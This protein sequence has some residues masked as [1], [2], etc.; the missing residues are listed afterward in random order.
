MNRYDLAGELQVSNQLLQREMHERRRAEGALGRFFHMSPD[1]MCITDYQGRIHRMN[2]VLPNLLGYKEKEFLEISLSNHI[3]PD[4]LEES[5]EVM[6]RA[7]SGETIRNFENRYLAKDGTVRWLSWTSVPAV[8]LGL[9]YSVGREITQQKSE[10]ELAAQLA[11]IVE[12]SDD[13]I[14]GS[15][16]EGIITSWNHSAK[17]IYGYSASE[18]LGRHITMLVPPEFCDEMKIILARIKAGE[19]LISYDTERIRKDGRRIFVAVT[20]SPIRDA[21]GRWIGYSTIARDITE[22]RRMANELSRLDRLN[23]AGKMAA[24][25][26]HEIRN[27]M[28]TVRGYLQWLQR[29]DGFEAFREQFDLMI[30]ELDR[31]NTIITEFLS[32]ARNKS[33]ESKMQNLNHIVTAIAPLIQADGLLENKNVELLLEPSIPDLPLDEKEIRQLILNL[34]RNGLEACLPGSRLTIS[35]YVEVDEVILEVADTGHGIA[36]E[37]MDKLGTPFF[38]TKDTGTGLGLAVCYQIAARHKGKIKV[39]SSPEGTAFSVHFRALLGG[40]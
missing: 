6:Y 34:A 40:G 32:L 11:A 5:M 12:F 15:D 22:K 18:V 26:G 27:P 31:A 24:S 37:L 30:A 3:H 19:R 14:I 7:A 29:K 9:I 25:I 10:Q 33:I 36:P 28:T 4:D 1:F 38:T 2:P 23:L 20:I 35:T 16:G 39:H 13:A 8:D 17:R 21:T